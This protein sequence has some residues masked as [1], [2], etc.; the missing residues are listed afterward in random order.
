MH[1]RIC[2][3]SQALKRIP[4]VLLVIAFTGLF[5]CRVRETDPPPET[6]TGVGTELPF[7]TILRHDAGQYEDLSPQLLLTLSHRPDTQAGGDTREPGIGAIKQAAYLN[8][9]GPMGPIK[10][11]ER[12]F[13]SPDG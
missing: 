3:R 5:A 13:G 1:T 10:R 4:L 12:R 9:P 2:L 8:T 6:T 7:E 11:T